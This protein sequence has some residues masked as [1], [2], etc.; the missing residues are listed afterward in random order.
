MPDAALL[1]R[2]PSELNSYNNLAEVYHTTARDYAKDIAWEQAFEEATLSPDGNSRSWLPEN[3]EINQERVN[4]VATYLEDI[5][6]AKGT[7]VAFLSNTR[8]E[9]DDCELAV[10]TAAGTVVGINATD[11]IDIVSYIL[12]DSGSEYVFAENQEQL[13]KLLSLVGQE[14]ELPAIPSENR[15]AQKV[16]IDLKKIICF[17]NVNVEEKYAHLADRVVQLGD[18]VKSSE[19]AKT[20]HDAMKTVG[21][22]DEATILYTSG[23]SGPPKGVVATHGQTLHNLRQILESDIWHDVRR[24]Y[25]LLPAAAHAFPRRMSQLTSTLPEAVA[26]YSSIVEH[27]TSAV[28]LKQKNSWRKDLREANTEVLCLVPKLIEPMYKGIK[29]G[30]DNKGIMGKFAKFVINNSIAI[31]KEEQEGIKAS[32]FAHKVHDLLQM[33][34]IGDKIKLKVSS[35]VFGPNMKYIVSGSAK[36]ETEIMY[37]FH[38]MGVPIFDGYGSTESNV[39]ITLNTPS[40]FRIGSVGK[41]IAKDVQ[42]KIS[43]EG[44]ILV[45]APNI[46]SKYHNRPVATAETFD[47]DGWYHTGDLGRMDKDGYLYIEGRND[48]V[49]KTTTGEKIQAEPIEGKL[50]LLYP[51]VTEAVLVGTG[52]PSLVALLNLDEKE[53]WKWAEQQGIAKTDDICSNDAIRKKVYEEISAKINSELRSFER[54]GNVGLIPELTVGDGLTAS[55]KVQRKYVIKKYEALIDKLYA[56]GRGGAAAAKPED[57][58]PQQSSFWQRLNPFRKRSE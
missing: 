54:I 58:K 57:K 40:A 34:D 21:R 25:H 42:I 36:L 26:I 11:K 15:P 52:R 16:T 43:D 38:G 19:V 37:F 47:A 35:K 14:V 32:W 50:K 29:E 51:F 45:K 7:R 6:V 46:V 4:K 23:T 27:D 2:D 53:A 20:V 13:D 10:F 49:I 9:W 18:V 41:V 56:E 24:I 8:R 48:S 30:L 39:P 31:L 3:Y 12:H 44:E 28:T 22:D 55:Q 1:E 17:E 5:G 33:G